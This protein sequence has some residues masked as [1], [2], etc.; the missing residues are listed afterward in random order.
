MKLH[1][2]GT[3]AGTEPMPDRN[4]QSTAIEINDTLYWFDA[5]AFCSKTAHLMGLDLLN[6][7]KVIISHP[8]MDHVGGLGNLFWDIRKLKAMKQ[9]ETKFDKIELYIPEME[10]WEGFSKILRNTEGSFS[11]MK[12]HAV[13]VKDGIVF[14]DENMSVTAFHNSH[15]GTPTDN[16]WKSFTY[17]IE[18]EGKRVIYSGDLGGLEELEPIIADGCD[19]LLIE[20]GHYHYLDVC[21]YMSSKKIGHLFFTHNGRSILNNPEK[22]PA[23]VRNSFGDNAVICSDG[24]SFVL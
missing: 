15:L 2:L 19:A 24:T 20:T 11:G 18:A 6:I 7:K 8:H 17:L 1:F 22:A 14:S 16:T 10:T 4:H 13:Q 21:R 5:G 12:I 23:D 9:R 3:C